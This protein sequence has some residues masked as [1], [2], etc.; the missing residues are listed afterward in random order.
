[1]ESRSITLES[2]TESLAW[3]YIRSLEKGFYIRTKYDSKL[4][5]V[6]EEILRRNYC[7]FKIEF[8]INEN[9]QLTIKSP[10]GFIKYEY[11]KRE[12]TGEKTMLK[13]ERV[14]G[15]VSEATVGSYYGAPRSSVPFSWRE[16]LICGTED[17]GQETPEDSTFHA[18]KN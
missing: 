11:R 12:I 6:L 5:K 18:P 7:K 15:L 8:L 9:K 2:S 1:M 14:R 10:G 17:N 3:S 13:N 16:D 4:V